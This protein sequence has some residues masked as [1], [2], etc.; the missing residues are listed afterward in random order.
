MTVYEFGKAVSLG[1]RLFVIKGADYIEILYKTRNI[2]R[3][4]DFVKSGNGE[5]EEIISKL[6][7][8]D[9][10]EVLYDID[11]ENEILVEEN[12]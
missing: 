1:T 8:I 7:D 4:I 2:A 6:I 9:S 12:D 10:K 3:Q 5:R 11:R